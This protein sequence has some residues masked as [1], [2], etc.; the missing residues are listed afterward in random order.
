MEL[1][2]GTCA[3]SSGLTRF[4]TLKSCWRLLPAAA[5]AAPLKPPRLGTAA[6]DRRAPG[7]EVTLAG[8]PKSI[9]QALEEARARLDRLTPQQAFGAVRIGALLVDTR[10][11]GAA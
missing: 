11:A 7:G 6:K 10:Y 9:D 5:G 8:G 2:Q 3:V 4:D 1:F